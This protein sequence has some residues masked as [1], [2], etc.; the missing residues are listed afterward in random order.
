MI[1]RILFCLISYSLK[2]IWGFFVCV[3]SWH[4]TKHDRMPLY[5]IL[6]K[7]YNLLNTENQ[8]QKIQL[9]FSVEESYGLSHL[10]KL[11]CYDL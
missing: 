11:S 8:Q 9:A 2:C 4:Q 5:Y 10:Y 1:T 6:P 3:T 7:N